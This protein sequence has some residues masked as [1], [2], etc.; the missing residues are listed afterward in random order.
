MKSVQDSLINPSV[1]IKNNIE[2]T[3]NV[4]DAMKLAN[5]RKIIYSSS[6]VVYGN[7]EIQPI[8]ENI[9]LK[10][11]S[12]YAKTKLTC[13]ELIMRASDSGYI[14]GISLRYFNPIGSHSSCLFKEQLIKKNSSICK[15]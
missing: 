7:Q 13:E 9:K 11:I 2:S 10:P 4:L 8:K 6:A 14:D 15:K 3:K 1:Y 5:C 12:T